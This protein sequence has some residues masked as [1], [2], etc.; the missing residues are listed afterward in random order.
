MPCYSDEFEGLGREQGE[1][2]ARYWLAADD[3][4]EAMDETVDMV[5]A[6]EEDNA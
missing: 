5:S 6:G 3:D 4:C 2:V 1:Q